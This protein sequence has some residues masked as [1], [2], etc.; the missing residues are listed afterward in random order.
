MRAQKKSEQTRFETKVLAAFAAAALVVAALAATTWKMSQNAVEG[1]LRL[2]HTHQVLNSLAQAKGNSFLIELSTQNYRISGDPARLVERDAAIAVRE[3]ALRQIKQ[4]T[5]DN[6]RQ[7]ARWTRMRE[8]VDQRLAISRHTELLR[9]TEGLE[10]ANAYVASAPLRETRE[11][12]FRVLGEMEEEE[13][14]LLEERQAGQARQD[15]IALATDL[16]AALAAIALLAATYVLIRRQLRATEASRRELEAINARV[17]AIFATVVD[18]I[19]TIDERGSV[20]TLN[21]AAERMFGYAAS[22][23]I[24]QNVKMLM[25]EPYQ[26]EHDGYLEHYR[27]TGEA[28]VIGIGREVV[29]RRKDGSIFPMYLAVSEMRVAG[30]RHFTGLVRDITARK[31]AEQEL[32]AAKEAAELANR[33]KD[34][35]LAT[36]SHE[37]RTPLGGLLGMLELLSL[38]P[39]S[40]DQSEVLQ[41]ARDS[42][43][44]LLRILNDI[45]DWSKIEEGKLALSPQPVSITMLLARVVNTYARVASA[46]SMILSSEVDPRLSP[47]LL[48]DPLRLSQVLNNFVSNAIKFSHEGGLIEVRAEL[49]ERHEG[50]EALRISVTDCGIG[51]A[52]EVQQR[53]F[54]NYGQGSAD[55]ARMYGGTGLGLAICRRLVDMMDG[56]IDLDSAP[57]R[58]STFSITLTLPITQ[59]VQAPVP[60]STEV[61]ATALAPPLVAGVAAADAP[62][63]LVVDDHPVN[64]K[65]LALQLGLLGLRSET[66]ENGAVALARWREGNCALVIT[67]CHMPVLDGYALARAIR[68]IETEQAGSRTPILAWTANAL[69]EEVGKCRAAGMDEVLVKP[70]DL[71]QL[72]RVLGKWLPAAEAKTAAPAEVEPPPPA[73]ASETA[74]EGGPALDVRVL[75]ALV[76][77]DPATLRQFLLDFGASAKSIAAELLGACAAGDAAQA[78]AQAHKLKS[79]AR[80]VGALALCQWCAELEEAG[81]AGQSAALASLAQGFKTEMAAVEAVLQDLTNPNQRV[82]G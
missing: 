67:D 45:L 12:L 64:R 23:L 4:L 56:R 31:Q 48:V 75:A 53:L 46:S 20:E 34:S 24:G 18:G 47:A 77:D 76:G 27:A 41:A 15:G 63:V 40:P 39:I 6:A 78:G 55:T 16:L 38:S 80:S 26:H 66:A 14:R 68:V 49:I 43:R 35:F 73:P 72:K 8:I 62:L 3:T 29:G 7:Q 59:A 11:R 13:L 2:S 74:R 33:A 42:G 1:A 19:I 30:E 17:G 28:R 65:L 5:A 50:T 69:A 79:A 81:K 82:S 71:E 51:I 22:E 61:A 25:P 36:M 10:A 44:S 58:G 21:P 32:V 57:G 37:I 52:P 60:P 70:V 54:Q 9:R